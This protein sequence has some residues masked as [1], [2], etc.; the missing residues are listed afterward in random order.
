[1]ILRPIIW[2]TPLAPM[3]SGSAVLAGVEGCVRHAEPVSAS[4]AQHIVKRRTSG[5][6]CLWMLKQVQHDR[7]GEGAL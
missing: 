6:D 7:L 1:P 5:Y 2:P 4:M 3:A